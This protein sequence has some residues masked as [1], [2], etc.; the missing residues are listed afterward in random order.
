MR[1]TWVAVLLASVYVRTD[2]AILVLVVLAYFCL[3]TDRLSI[4][5]AFVLGGMAIA[6]VF[7]INHFAGDYGWRMLYYR[8]FIAPP[9]APGEFVAQFTFTDYLHALRSGISSAINDQFIPFLLAGV[10]GVLAPQKRQIKALFGIALL[11]SAA[12]F[13]IFP[14]P[15][16]RYF[17]V[18]F[19]IMGLTA[20]T[21][22]ANF[23]PASAERSTAAEAVR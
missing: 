21:A 3:L 20:I 12:R 4:S 23:Y 11:Y 10:V 19:L 17:S 5:K 16:P 15:E 9:L 14:L 2:N 22:V 6:S 7:L 1:R 13:I 18:F 8:A